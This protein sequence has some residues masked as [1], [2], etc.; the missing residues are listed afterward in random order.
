VMWDVM[1][2]FPALPWEG[3]S[4]AYI[5]RQVTRGAL[6]KPLPKKPAP[7]VELM[8]ECLAYTASERPSFGECHYRLQSLFGVPA[9]LVRKQVRMLHDRIR[10]EPGVSSETKIWWRSVAPM[11]SDAKNWRFQLASWV[12]WQMWGFERNSVS[13]RTKPPVMQL[14]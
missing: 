3:K 14:S 7:L 11:P 10:A 4:Q 9:Q 12:M 13:R 1:Q 6:P 5:K 2:N 8:T